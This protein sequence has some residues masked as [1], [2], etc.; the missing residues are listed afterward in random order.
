MDIRL[1]MWS[2]TRKVA[3]QWLFWSSIAG[4]TGRVGGGSNGFL[5]WVDTGSRCGSYCMKS[6]A[7][8]REVLLVWG[9]HV[10]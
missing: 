3:V 4:G 9:F 7:R 5:D 1:S 10:T 6:E 8:Q 2:W